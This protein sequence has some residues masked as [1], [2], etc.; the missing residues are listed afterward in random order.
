MRRSLPQAAVS[1]EPWPRR[2]PTTPHETPAAAIRGWHVTWS[3]DGRPTIVLDHDP[4]PRRVRSRSR[5]ILWLHLGGRPRVVQRTTT[6]IRYRGRRDPAYRATVAWLEQ[7]A[8]PRGADERQM[9]AGTRDERLGS[10]VSPLLQARLGWRDR[11]RRGRFLSA[12][13]P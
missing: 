4:L 13:G 12:S 8:I 11:R 3:H 9:P 1:V 10:S 7:L 5:T 6:S 2:V